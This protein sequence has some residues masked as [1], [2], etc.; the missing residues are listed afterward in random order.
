MNEQIKNLLEQSGLQPYYDAQE[1]HIERFAELIVQE[2][3]ELCRQESKKEFNNSWE[4][5]RAACDAQMILAYF[6]V[7]R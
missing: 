2:C 7:E 5:I 6:G 3:A 1:G 4:R